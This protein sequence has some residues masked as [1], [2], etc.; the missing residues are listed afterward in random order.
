MISEAQVFEQLERLFSDRI[1]LDEFEDWLA[2]HS[3]DM[4]LDS[5]KEA[6]ELVWAIELGLSEYSS[7][8]IDRLGLMK[9]FGG[10]IAK[11]GQSSMKVSSIDH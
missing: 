7:S 10:I 2:L 8:H 1:D 3:W 6:K 11:T 5:S 4:H 9:R